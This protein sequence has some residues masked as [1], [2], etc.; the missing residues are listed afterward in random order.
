LALGDF[1]R[2]GR[3]DVALASV[4]ATTVNVLLNACR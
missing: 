4:G 1:N 2:D 3:Q